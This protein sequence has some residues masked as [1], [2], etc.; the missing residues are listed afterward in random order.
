MNIPSYLYNNKFAG[1]YCIENIINHK[2]YIGSSL[3]IY[4]RLHVH[5]V[6]LSK[7]KHENGYLQNAVNKYG[8]DNFE[9]YMIELVENIELL[10][11]K[12]QYWIDKLNS[13]YNLTKEVMRN[14]LSQESRD[15][16]SKTLKEG[17]ANGNISKT[18]V[19]PVDVYDLDGNY[20]KSFPT[21]RECGRELNLHATSIIR[22]LNGQYSQVK[23]YQVKY[24]KDSKVIGKIIL[25]KYNH[26]TQNAINKRN[27]EITK[28]Q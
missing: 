5:K 10:T 27:D 16:I 22:V 20:I 3:N 13:E 28:K 8:I 24:S 19:S 2:R 26:T 6:K 18:K 17:Y 21:I 25:S 11:A 4:Q 7:N 14:I 23:G 12:E 9:S 15:K 1:I